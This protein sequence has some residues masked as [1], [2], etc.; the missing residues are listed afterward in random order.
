MTSCQFCGAPLDNVARPVPVARR[1]AGPE[2]WIL[3]L[4][5]IVA[6]YWIFD[7][8]KELILAFR[9]LASTTTLHPE[10][11]F[12]S[13]ILIAIGL[14]QLALGVGLLLK[15]E[16]ARGVVNIFCWIRILFALMALAGVVMGGFIAGPLFSLMTIFF[17][18]LDLVV[19]GTQ[20]WLISETDESFAR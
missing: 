7:G 16:W 12:I 13:Y 10:L 2:P 20:I 3:T 14:F 6:G 19:A 5:M 15:W 1:K 9:A 4:Y 11:N 17:S 8:I 18:V